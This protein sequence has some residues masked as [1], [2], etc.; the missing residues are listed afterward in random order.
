MPGPQRTLCLL[1]TYLRE[2]VVE[3]AHLT[4]HE[5]NI[6]QASWENVSVEE[7]PVAVDVQPVLQQPIQVLVA[8]TEA[9]AVYHDVGV[10]PGAVREGHAVLVVR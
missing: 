6:G 1:L 3:G 10:Q 2:D 5:G 9:R 4:A 8:L 7:E